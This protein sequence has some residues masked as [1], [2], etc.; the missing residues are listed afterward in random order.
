MQEN[1]LIKNNKFQKLIKYIFIF[2][3]F[4]VAN[5]AGINNLF[6]PFIFGLFFAFLWCNQNVFI[7]SILYILAGFLSNF[8]L[9]SLT[10]NVIFVVLFLI[11]YGIHYKIKKPFKYLHIIIYACICLAPKI[12]IEIYFLNAN[13]YLQFVELLFGLLYTFAV[14]KYFESV[15][16]RGLCGRLTNLETICAI[17]FVVSIFCG[18]ANFNI[19]NIDLV[20]FFGVL[21]LL[22]FGYISNIQTVLLLTLGIGV[23]CLLANGLLVYMG[24]FALFGL[25]IC[26]FRTKNKYITCVA[27][28]AVECLCGFYFNFYTQ[29]DV[30]SLIPVF[31]ALLI[32]V[33]FPTKILDMYSNRFNDNLASLTQSSVINR[34]REMLYKRL[35]ELSDVFAEMNKVF[36]GMIS[37]EVANMSA[38]KLVFNEIKISIC[39]DCPNKAKCYRLVDVQGY[40]L[41]MIDI[42]FE[43]GKVN[44][45]DVPTP[46]AGKCDKLN[47]L[48]SN[49]N[50]LIGQYK[51]YAGLINNIDASKV[52]LAEQLFGVSKIM[53]DL[54]LE[55]KNDVNFEKGKEKKIIDELTYNNVICSDAL[56]FEDYDNIKSVTLAVRKDDSQKASISRVVSKICNCK[57]DVVSEESSS[58]AGWQVLSLKSSPKYD[59]IFG[60]ATKTKTGSLASG[61]CYSIIKISD[62][63]YLFALCDG[64]GSGQKAQDTSSTAIELLEN[65]YKAGFDKEIIISSLN[66]LLSMCN[67]ENFSALDL[68]VIDVREGVGDFI[69]MGATQSFVKH[70]DTTQIIEIGA[71]PLGIVQNA[72]TKSKEIYF[73]SGD[74]VVLMTDGVSDSFD[75]IQKFGDFVNN[76]STNNPQ[77]YA[78]IILNKALENNKKI[79]KDDMS[80]I[81][82]KIFER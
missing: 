33:I 43:K 11:I 13:I 35:V 63:K 10:E 66:K 73:S 23:G 57:M 51:N 67:D 50:D 3:L 39:K 22:I 65:F 70:K 24:V 6:Y 82:A 9:F 19:Y 36:R 32:F 5:N 60:I 41:Q 59:C 12:F 2:G 47:S 20:K 17:V 58:R 28:L 55:V 72:E 62:S 45:L 56:V 31:V 46:F 1:Q 77:E 75:S 4:F 49:I 48:V 14:M 74:K 38:K 26:I 71:L 69:K 16:V 8:S 27:L 68:C 15:C 53:Q 78:D 61:D 42:G 29:F 25:T 30:V 44:I 80:V 7:L 54:S 81:V 21:L 76:I 52:M 37:G 34:N 64:M 40:I 79:A 18:L